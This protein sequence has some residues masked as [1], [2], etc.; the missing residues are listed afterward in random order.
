MITGYYGYL[1]L[2][3]QGAV[4]HYITRHMA[5][6]N[7]QQLNAKANSAFTVLSGLGIL[8][9][10]LSF[11]VSRIFPHFIN[12]D[13]EGIPTV[14]N[15]L[16]ILGAATALKFPLSIFQGMII[17]AQRFDLVSGTALFI[18]LINASCIVLALRGDMGLL[19]MACI[20]F[21]TQ[22]L[23]GLIG[24]VLAFRVQPQIKLRCPSF[25]AKVFGE[26]FNYGAFNFL[27]GTF[28]QFGQIAGPFI[29][30]KAIGSAAVTYYNIGSE[31]LPYMVGLIS[32]V[33]T[34]LLQIVIPMD[35]KN[36]LNAIRSLLLTG[37]RY[38]FAMVCIIALNLLL[39]GKPFLGQWMGEKYLLAE[40]YGSSSTVLVLLTLANVAA[41]SSAV[42]QQILFGRRKNKI[43]AAFILGETISTFL[44]SLFLVKPYGMLGIAFAALIPACLFEGFIIPLSTA[45]Q[46]GSSLLEF[47][48]ISVL[49]NITLATVTFSIGFFLLPFIPFHGW[50]FLFAAGCCI[51][52]FHLGV[53]Y[54][55][56]V[57]KAHRHSFA[58]AIKIKLGMI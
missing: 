24:I 56:I 11:V 20:N 38:L 27:I 52:L 33:S 53:T 5:D 3:M 14:R 29:I 30:G 41:L 13:P 45:R 58:A 2:G 26:L 50:A 16:L 23:E 43:F 48:R 49:P 36:D 55:F 21:S 35:V 22:I 34:P 1:D 18:R 17:G 46:V 9:L 42:A 4:G 6:G 12:I 40:P 15:A 28:Y 31:M 54:R 25:E 8:I 7:I 44:L 51:T 57:A 39:L 32:A 37:S 19:A 10:I 47:W